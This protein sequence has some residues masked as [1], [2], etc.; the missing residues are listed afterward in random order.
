[1]RFASVGTLSGIDAE[2]GLGSIGGVLTSQ[3]RTPNK[4]SQDVS[5][6]LE[7][8][9]PVARFEVVQVQCGYGGQLAAEVVGDMASI[10]IFAPSRQNIL[11][12]T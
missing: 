6:C 7:A 1:M 11:V 3:C 9:W 5:L 2:D 10:G 8:D 4:V 12:R